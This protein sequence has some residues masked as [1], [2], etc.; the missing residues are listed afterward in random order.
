MIKLCDYDKCTGCASC[1]SACAHNSIKMR[2]SSEG[3]LYP[4]IDINTCTECGLCQTKCPELNPVKF[5]AEP[6]VYAC[7]SLDD[8]VRESSSSGGMFS[9]LSR[10]V[11]NTGG[12]VF[13]VV[14]NDDLDA[15]HTQASTLQE[16]EPMKGSKY[17]QSKIGDT[18]KQAK[19]ALSSDKWVLFSGTPCQIAGLL[20]FIPGHLGEKL[21]TVDMVCHGVPSSDIFKDYL[22][23]LSLL[24]PDINKPSYRFRSTKYWGYDP[25][26]ESGGE[27]IKIKNKDNIFMKL[28]LSNYLFRESCYSCQYTKTQRISDVT[29]ADFWGLGRS[30]KFEHNTKNGVSLSL[31]NSPKGQEIFED[32]KPQIFS[33]RRE[34]DEAKAQNHQLYCNS[35]RPKSGRETIYPYFKHHN[36]TQVY[37]KYLKMREIDKAI[38]RVMKFLKLK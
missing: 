36:F 15:V 17:I 2:L 22:D 31:V 5:H 21:I 25:S 20:K 7:W 13:G 32:I 12:V 26:F 10:W 16:L 33:Q 37:L 4:Q 34:L 6:Q 24:Y 14:L 27:R 38:W 29:I 1:Y 23:K 8:K 35:K 19:Q 9:H 30:V 11:L 3:F 28:F 18:F